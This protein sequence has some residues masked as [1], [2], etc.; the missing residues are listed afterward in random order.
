M[1]DVEQG[2]HVLGVGDVRQSGAQS[3]QRLRVCGD[4]RQ[5]ALQ[6]LRQRAEP[7]DLVHEHSPCGCV[8]WQRSIDHQLPHVLERAA[9]GQ[10]DRRVLPV[11]VEAFSSTNVADLGVGNHDALQPAGDLGRA[12]LGNSHQIAQ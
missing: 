7:A 4:R 3:V 1:V 6:P 9:R 11:V 5:Q 8:E 12:D 2:T 10:V